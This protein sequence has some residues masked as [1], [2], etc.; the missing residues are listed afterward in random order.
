M[1][2]VQTCALPISTTNIKKAKTDF[3][4]EVTLDAEEYNLANNQ[5]II[6]RKADDVGQRRYTIAK[7][8]YLL[9]K[10]GITDLNIAQTDR[11]AAKRAYIEVLKNSWITYYTLRKITL[12]DFKK[13]MTL[14][15]EVT[16]VF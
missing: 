11:D 5:L 2:G 14:D 10:I 1:T 4:Q 15:Q 8:R 6:A 9:G 16:G 12:Y 3:E 13:L 7:Q